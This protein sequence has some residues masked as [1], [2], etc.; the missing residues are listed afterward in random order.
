VERSA[1]A[2]LEDVVQIE[3]VKIAVLKRN[4]LH[5]NMAFPRLAANTIN[6]IKKDLD[7]WYHKLPPIMHL[8]HLTKKDDLSSVSTQLRLTIYF[9]HLLYLGALILF[10][11]RIAVQSSSIELNAELSMCSDVSMS[12][13]ADDSVIAAERSARILGPLLDEGNVFKRCWI[14]M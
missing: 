3:M 13:S 5:V 12:K 8:S 6:T 2:D 1:S 9:V 4:I 7:W 11:R 14:V 10:N